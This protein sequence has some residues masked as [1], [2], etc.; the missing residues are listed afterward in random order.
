MSG[1]SKRIERHKSG[2]S[3]VESVKGMEVSELKTRFKRVDY[4]LS[5]RHVYVV[6][7]MNRR[8]AKAV[9]ALA[10]LQLQSTE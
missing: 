4:D 6:V 5:G 9:A 1:F 7:S 2:L 8:L 10:M 3:S